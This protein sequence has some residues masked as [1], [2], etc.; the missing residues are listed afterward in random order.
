MKK[1]ILF[2]VFILSSFVCSAQSEVYKRVDQ[3]GHIIYSDIQSKGADPI[4]LPELT[5]LPAQSTEVL[6]AKSETIAAERQHEI[7]DKTGDVA[8]DQMMGSGAAQLDHTT[9]ATTSQMSDY[10]RVQQ[11]IEDIELYEDNIE[12]LEIELYNLGGGY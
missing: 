5:V 10:D 4:E 3:D 2:F 11:L 12:A 9:Q 7:I 1:V 8:T 6:S